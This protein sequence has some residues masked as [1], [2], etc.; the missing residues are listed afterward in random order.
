MIE[1]YTL[2]RM[3]KVWTDENRFS[4]WLDIEVLICEAYGE[5]SLIPAEDL[6]TIKERARFDVGKILEIEKRTKH[7]VVAFIECVSEYVGPSSKY[8]HMGATSSDILDTSFACLLKEASDILVEDITALMD[9]LKEKAYQHK[10]T[11]AIGRTHGIHAEPVTFGL[12]I[13][14]F[15][16]EMRRNLERMKAA[17]ERVSYG[18]I[19]GAVGTY[20]HVP[21]FVEEYV[22]RKLGLKA[23]PISSQ[24]I[25]RDYHAEFFTTLALIGSSIERM[26]MEIRSL[27]RTEVGEAEE[28]FS[29]GQTGSSAMPHKRNPIASENLCGLARLLHGYA[30]SSM[31]NIPLWHERDI[32]HSSVERVIAPDATIAL[33]YMFERVKNLFKNLIVYPEKMLGN[34]NISKG[35]Y[36]SEAILLAIIRKG[37]TRQEAYK[38]TQKVA[39]H[40]YENKL[41]FAAELKKDPDIGKYLSSEEIQATCSNDHYFRHVDRIFERVFG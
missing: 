37:L 7:D 41:D 23:A 6:K 18:K 20:A 32:S 14:H 39:M 5:L 25:P 35:L 34:M 16:D 26:A 40:C 21:P 8:I 30:L 33:D 19:S 9:V 27:Q 11:P 29:K 31:E 4:K 12:K 22:C 28:F 38:L 24:I 10:M 13:A 2:Q 15:Y 17:R 1:R 3:A 36:H